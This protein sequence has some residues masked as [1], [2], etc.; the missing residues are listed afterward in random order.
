VAEAVARLHGS[1]LELTDRNPGL[2]VLLALP[3]EAAPMAA[4]NAATTP[5]AQTASIAATAA[6]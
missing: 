1:T 3:P 6:S 2:C 5:A 4:A